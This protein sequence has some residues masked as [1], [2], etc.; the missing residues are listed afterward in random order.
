MLLLR[1]GLIF[2]KNISRPY[3][4]LGV[5]FFCLRH[6][7]ELWLC[8]VTLNR[9]LPLVDAE[10][11]WRCENRY[12]YLLSYLLL[13]K[14]SQYRYRYRNSDSGYKYPYQYWFYWPL[15]NMSLPATN[16]RSRSGKG[17]HFFAGAKALMRCGLS[18]DPY[19]CFNTGTGTYGTNKQTIMVWSGTGNKV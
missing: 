11:C 14:C 7:C 13:L 16:M 18:S 3:Y 17:T 5:K 1:V 2:A 10:I 15:Q 4:H 12:R 6:S 19:F 9:L 8:Y